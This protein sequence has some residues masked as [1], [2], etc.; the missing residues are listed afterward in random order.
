MFIIL[1][2]SL[3]S[4]FILKVVMFLLLFLEASPEVSRKKRYVSILKTLEK[5]YTHL[6]TLHNAKYSKR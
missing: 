2:F 3:I 4:S 5:K 1:T 6:C